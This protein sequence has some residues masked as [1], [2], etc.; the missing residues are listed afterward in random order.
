MNTPIICPHCH[1]LI[2]PLTLETAV[3]ATARYQVCPECDRPIILLAD[4]AD[5]DPA[6]T[7]LSGVS[8]ADTQL[9]QAA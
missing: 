3:S 1:S 4:S 7:G 9:A 2:D 5:D 6:D 8:Q